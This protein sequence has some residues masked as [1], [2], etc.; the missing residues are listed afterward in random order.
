MIVKY[1]HILDDTSLIDAKPWISVSKQRLL[2][3]DGREMNDYYQVT[4]P[5]YVEI[6]PVDKLG[7]IL[8]Q[9]RYKHGPR[10]FN[11]AFLDGYLK[12]DKSPENAASRE[13]HEECGFTF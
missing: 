1:W 6:I 2:F 9:W 12:D 7:N 10:K 8:S 3:P 11:L 4:S 13:L 5:S